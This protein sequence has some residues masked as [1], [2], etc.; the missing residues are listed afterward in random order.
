M[1][2][3]RLFTKTSTL[4]LVVFLLCAD[5]HAPYCCSILISDLTLRKEKQSTMKLS[6]IG[7]DECH[8]LR[9]G[10]GYVEFTALLNNMR[11]YLIVDWMTDMTRYLL[12]NPNQGRCDSLR[13]KT[14]QLMHRF[15]HV[16]SG[17]QQKMDS[18]SLFTCELCCSKASVIDWFCCF[19]N[20]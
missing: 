14:A 8:V 19:V 16:D 9:T 11:V 20:V 3:F 10:P 5:L 2:L 15:G 4:I 13:A 6:N 17:N 1:Y 7:N 12:E 18:V